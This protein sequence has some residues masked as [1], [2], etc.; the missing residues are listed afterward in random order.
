MG[1]APFFAVLAAS[2]LVDLNVHSRLPAGRIGRLAFCSLA[3]GLSLG[4]PPPRLL[5]NFYYFCS[6]PYVFVYVR[7]ENRPDIIALVVLACQV[8]DHVVFGLSFL[9][10]PAR[11]GR[12]APSRPR[13]DELHR[14]DLTSPHPCVSPFS[15]R[16]RSR[17]HPRLG[18]RRC[19]A[20]G[21][22]WTASRAAT[23]ASSWEPAGQ[24]GPPCSPRARRA[25]LRAGRTPGTCAVVCCVLF[26]ACCCSIG[27][28]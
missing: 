18:T 13:I 16:T 17:Q 3:D 27:L 5:S 1:R 12:P 9:T 10:R 22:R 8:G 6:V 7:G 23:R 4:T 15:F 24:T 19:T 21:S 26:R 20:R 14:Y 28:V 2:V 11:V 25:G